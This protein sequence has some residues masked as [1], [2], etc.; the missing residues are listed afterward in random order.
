[1]RADRGARRGARA[2]AAA[3]NP[4]GRRPRGRSAPAPARRL[5]DKGPGRARRC[6]GAV[7]FTWDQE[8]VLPA[9]SPVSAV[10]AARR[11]RRA[12]RVAA[13]L[14]TRSAGPARAPRQMAGEGTLPRSAAC[15]GRARR[16][17]RG[18]NLGLSFRFVSGARQ[19]LRLS[20]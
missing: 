3:E 2:G 10:H 20:V 14:C 17:A 11:A 1:M 16:A 9:A 13:G 5:G 6:P 8:H 18:E 4:P 15:R 12:L 19:W 7:V